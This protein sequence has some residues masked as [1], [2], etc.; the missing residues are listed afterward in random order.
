MEDELLAKALEQSE[1]DEAAR[2]LN[3]QVSIVRKFLFKILRLLLFQNANDNS[4][5]IIN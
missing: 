4:S 2:R 5:C 1:K 3:A